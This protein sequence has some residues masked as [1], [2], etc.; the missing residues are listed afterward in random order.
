MAP[1][2]PAPNDEPT[3][4]KCALVPRPEDPTRADVPVCR[5]SN[6]TVRERSAVAPS[7]PARKPDEHRDNSWVGRIADTPAPWRGLLRPAS[8]PCVV[9]PPTSAACT[10]TRLRAPATQSAMADRRAG[11]VAVVP[12]V[13]GETGAAAPW[14]SPFTPAMSRPAHVDAAVGG[15]AP[16]V[17]R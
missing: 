5:A 15:R 6:G 17:E 12:P 4:H 10:P 1:P 13:P 11:A 14:P 16:A 8:S 9:R 2:R 3:N 7:G